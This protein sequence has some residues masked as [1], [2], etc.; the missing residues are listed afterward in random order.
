SVNSSACRC[1]PGD[2]CWPT[3]SEWDNFNQTL[4]GKLIATKPLASVCHL[5]LFD[6]YDAQICADLQANWTLP[7]T[8][9][10]TSSSIMAPYYANQSCDPFLP[11]N[12]QCVIGTYIQY[13]VNASEAS[14]YQKTINFIKKRNIRLTIRN[15]GH[16]YYGK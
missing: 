5:D 1:F 12:S 9:Y 11:R 14:D 7:E 13:A 16:D 10:V 15:T 6:T 8:H 3:K 2:T 4:R